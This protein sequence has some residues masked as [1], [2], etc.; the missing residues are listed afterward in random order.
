ML[1]EDYRDMLRILCDNE[2]RFL[3]VGAYAMAAHGYAH[4]TGDI[5]IWVEPSADNATKVYRSVLQFGAPGEQIDERTFVGKNV[6]FQIGVA[7]RR[8]DI[9]T[10]IS[11]VEFDEAYRDRT[12]IVIDDIPAPFLSREHLI[13]SKESTGRDKD[14]LDAKRLREKRQL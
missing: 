10:I 12:T 3:I 1:N 7:P 9:S 6:V 4:G 11:G 13:R 14:K 8:I 5:D 2:V